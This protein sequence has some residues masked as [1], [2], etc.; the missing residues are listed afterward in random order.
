MVEGDEEVI[1]V[2]KLSVP[3]EFAEQSSDDDLEEQFSIG[4][5]FR[6]QGFDQAALL[7]FPIEYVHGGGGKSDDDI[8]VEEE[9]EEEEEEAEQ[10]WGVE[11]EGVDGWN[12][13]GNPTR[14]WRRRDR[15]NWWLHERRARFAAVIVAN[16]PSA[17]LHL[18]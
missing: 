7:G 12:V 10:M 15:H 5:D 16:S 8:I 14:R 17:Y 11:G 2:L 9:E 1:S 13:H 3:I 6:F 4:P 18:R